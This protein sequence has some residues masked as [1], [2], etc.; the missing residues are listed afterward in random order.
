MKTFVRQLGLFVGLWCFAL[1]PVQ[2]QDRPGVELEQVETSDIISEVSLNG[3]VNALRTSRLSTAV[4]G[5][6]ESVQVETGDRVSE[7][8]LLIG[9]DDEQAEFELESARAEAAEARARLQEAQRRLTEARSVGAGR[10]IAATEVSARESEVAATEA[11]L[12]RFRAEERRHQVVLDRHRIEAPFGGVV[13]NRARDLGEWVTPGNELLTLVDITNLRL[14][15]RVPQDYYQRIADDSE[16][17]V[18]ARAAD[19]KSV[20]VTIESLVPVSDTQARTFLLRATGPEELDVLPGMAVQATLRVSTGEQG[21]TVSRDA[22][23][24]YPD[25]RVTVWIAEPAEEDL[26]QVREKRVELGSSFDNRME[27]LGGLEG[28]EQV[29]IRGNESLEDGARVRLAERGSR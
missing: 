27:I 15:F 11:A 3:T 4:A 29:V 6:V 23:D 2:A 14:D 10:N 1:F 24:R 9:L 16:L 5:L 7:G 28:G 13:S 17:L 19:Q 26:Y 8:D 22:I 21:L 18:P 25:G 20:P 12:A